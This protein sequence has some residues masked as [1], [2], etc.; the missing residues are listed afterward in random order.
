VK[1]KKSYGGLSQAMTPEN[2][3]G[4][5]DDDQALYVQTCN[6]YVERG[7][8]SIPFLQRKLRI[9]HSKAKKLIDRLN[10]EIEKQVK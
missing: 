3:T 2:C 9:S 8:S 7:C 1:L 4:F 10:I 6:M 5:S